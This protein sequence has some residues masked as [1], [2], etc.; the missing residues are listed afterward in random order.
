MK[1]WLGEEGGIER[2]I[3][4]TNGFPRFYLTVKAFGWRMRL[5]HLRTWPHIWFGRA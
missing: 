5:W 4:V 3:L 1:V 2:V